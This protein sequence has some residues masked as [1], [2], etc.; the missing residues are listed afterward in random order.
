MKKADFKKLRAENEKLRAER[1]AVE[2]FIDGWAVTAVAEDERHE[3]EAK[4]LAAIIDKHEATIKLLV[5]EI[6]HYNDIV[7]KMEARASNPASEMLREDL[8]IAE[9]LADQR[10]YQIKCYEETI[11]QLHAEL[12]AI[13]AEADPMSPEN[14]KKHVEWQQACIHGSVEM[15]TISRAEALNK[16]DE[17]KRWEQEALSKCT[18]R[19]GAQSH[20]E[21]PADCGCYHCEQFAKLVR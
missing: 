13:E 3:A 2:R 5:A 12:A 6:D 21:H 8:T 14:I 19:S 20:P 4:G 17:L 11:K 10:L 16:L 9:A 15:G 7:N 1:D 18:A